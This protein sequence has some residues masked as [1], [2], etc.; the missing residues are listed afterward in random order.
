ML[1]CNPHLLPFHRHFLDL[2]WQGRIAK[3]LD[4][5][6]YSEPLWPQRKKT[7]TEGGC[8][9]LAKGIL[10]WMLSSSPIRDNG[11]PLPRGLQ[12][13]LSTDF[14]CMD[15]HLRS[16][17]ASVY[18]LR[19]IELAVWESW[20]DEPYHVVVALGPLCLDGNGLSDCDTLLFEWEDY[21][22]GGAYLG[23]LSQKETIAYGIPQHDALS[24]IITK[25]LRSA[26]GPFHPDL[27]FPTGVHFPLLD[28]L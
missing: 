16:M 9:I 21:F 2:L 18:S 28:T 20:D 13:L 7:W 8:L 12:P 6:Q 25:E 4:E 23:L 14:S 10:G 22:R 3:L 1:H 15:F 26:F 5:L 24:L 19:P 17:T 11:T 27:L